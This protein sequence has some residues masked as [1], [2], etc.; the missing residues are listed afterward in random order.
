MLMY[1]Y[2]ENI[3]DTDNTIVF[4][5]ASM[6]EGY[7]RLAELV[8]PNNI[9]RLD[10]RDFDIFYAEYIMSCEPAFYKMFTVVFEL[11]QSHDVYLIINEFEWC[12]NLVQSLFKFIQTR[13]GYNGVRINNMEDYIYY[14]NND[15]FKFNPDYGL[16]NFDLDKER[17]SMD[18]AMSGSLNQEYMYD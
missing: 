12:D 16:Y 3:P 7:Q 1:G 10:G 11:F 14:K 8:P 13:Y 17:Y 6:K 15:I 18:V 5:L 9:G 2:A 4:N